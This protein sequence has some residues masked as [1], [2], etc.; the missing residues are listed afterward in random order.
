MMVVVLIVGLM[1]GVAA[2]RMD[3]LVPKY[4]LRGAARGI[5]ALLTQ[6]RARAA[7]TGKDVFLEIDLS[8][9]RYWLLAAFPKALEP[10]EDEKKPRPL[11]YEAVLHQEI[12]DDVQVTDVVLGASEKI[13]RGRARVRL[14]PF[15]AGGH[16]IVNLKNKEDR[17][18]SVR[19]NGFTGALSFS[20]E[21]RDAEDLLED[22]GR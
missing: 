7:G 16:V 10:G 5:G 9:N 20:D 12:P 19:L 1:V 22:D 8:K 6:A 14:S 17:L 3:H 15:G 21:R 13:D 11:I 4:R 18:M 2:V